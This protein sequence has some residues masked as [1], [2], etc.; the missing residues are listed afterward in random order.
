MYHYVTTV[1]VLFFLIR[2]ESYAVDLVT[3][4]MI[5]HDDRQRFVVYC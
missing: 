4:V 1:L 3:V 2:E 5:Y